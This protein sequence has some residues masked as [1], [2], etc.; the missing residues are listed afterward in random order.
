MAEVL[1]DGGQFAHEQPER[2]ADRREI[3]RL[4]DLDDGVAEAEI[5]A[6]EARVGFAAVREVVVA[7]KAAF[8]VVLVGARRGN[9]EPV[10][11]LVPDDMAEVDEL[12]RIL[13]E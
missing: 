9:A 1:G 11:V 10:D 7:E 12:Q 8:L 5:G 13:L 3:D 6:G 4:V 2:L